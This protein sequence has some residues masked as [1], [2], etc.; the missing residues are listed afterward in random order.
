[1]QA[2][3]CL[4]LL[5]GLWLGLPPA[6]SSVELDEPLPTFQSPFLYTQDFPGGADRLEPSVADARHIRRLN[7]S[8]AHSI[9]THLRLVRDTD[10]FLI[11]FSSVT[12]RVANR[13]VCNSTLTIFPPQ[14]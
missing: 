9:I 13:I 2:G 5:V 1:M 14:S 7:G 3:H 11:L 12:N 10:L 4:A 8:L 6:T